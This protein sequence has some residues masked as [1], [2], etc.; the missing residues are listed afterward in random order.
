MTTANRTNGDLPRITLK[1]VPESSLAEWSQHALRGFRDS[2][3]HLKPRTV[4]I[5]QIPA[6]RMLHYFEHHGVVDLY[7]I[8]CFMLAEIS[9]NEASDNRP[10]MIAFTQYIAD[11]TARP[12]CVEAVNIAH[13]QWL[14]RLTP[15]ERQEWLE[16]KN[17]FP[18]ET[19]FDAYAKLTAYCRSR[20]YSSITLTQN[21]GAFADLSLFFYANKLMFSHELGER[22]IDLMLKRY[23]RICPPYYLT[24]SYRLNG[25]LNG[26]PF[27]GSQLMRGKSKVTTIPDWAQ[28]AYE[29]FINF[30]K[31]DGIC[32]S[33]ISM[34][35]NCITNF[36]DYLNSIGCKSFTEITQST[37]KGFNLA[38]KHKTF[39]SKNAHNNRVSAFLKWLH[40]N[41]YITI[42][43]ANALPAY[44]AEQRL[45]ITVLSKEED[46]T[47]VAYLNLDNPT[48]RFYYRDVAMLKIMRYMGL[49]SS[50][51]VSLKFSEIN[52]SECRLTKIQEK[53]GKIIDM[54][55]PVHV[56]NSIINYIEKERPKPE[57]PNNHI[58]LSPYAPHN[59]ITKIACVHALKRAI[60]RTN[61]HILR[62]TFAS[63]LMGNTD[64]NH[65]SEILGHQDNNTVV[66]YLNTD[67]SRMKECILSMNEIEYSGNLL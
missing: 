31:E 38:D 30:R 27:D 67:T 17:T 54:P 4:Y 37:I 60:G 53:T 10:G 19:I 3:R 21:E 48:K 43:L 52:L 1:T 11:V 15:Q 34:I 55:I 58:F 51:V 9:C 28:E 13:C 26:Y 61:T 50:D 56:L 2:I 59:T 36:L 24:L 5:Y 39:Y 63:E 22:W 47:L 33:T 6:R 64:I 57:Y 8:D 66:K 40:H 20:G 62:R 14:I 7:G 49:R 32:D 46:E 23:G 65:I 16:V 25:I 29:R 35:R 12:I 42:D 41:N 18:C 44:A 45:P